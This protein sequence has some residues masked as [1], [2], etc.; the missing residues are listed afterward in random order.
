MRLLLVMPT[1]LRVGYDDYFS[2]APMG[3]ETLAAHARQFADV[4]LMDMRG[5][6]H[7]VEAHADSL[8]ADRPDIIGVSVNS[9]PHTKYA[10]ALAQALRRRDGRVR[11]LVGGQQA[12][13]LP[14]EMLAPGCFDALVRG[15]GEHAICEIL[16]RGGDAGGVPGVSWRGNGQIHHEPDRPL[17]ANLDEILPPAR[18][19]L[20]DRARYRMGKYRIE[21]IESSR[22]CPYM[23][24]FCSVRNFHRGKW[25]PKSVARVLQEVDTILELYHEPKVIYFADDNFAQDIG[26]VA[27]IC[28]G[29]IERRTDAH[30]W[31]QA[32]VDRL[33]ANPEVIALMGKAKFSAVLVGIETPVKR[34]LKEAKKGTSPE[35]IEQAIKLL[36]Q[37]DIGVWGTFTLGLPGETAEETKLT[38]GYLAKTKVDV[39]QITVATPIPGSQLYEDA[40]AKGEILSGDWDRFDFTSPLIKGQLDKPQLDALM[41]R[42][43]LKTYLSWRFFAALF[44][45]KTNLQRLRRTAFG[46]FSSF[47]RL[48]LKETLLSLF[49]RRK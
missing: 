48:A 28:T 23:C 31:C 39:A 38:A 16:R 10:L 45:Q 6:G 8:L 41:R 33:A 32:R 19:L 21:G 49:H 34:L 26:R 13:F 20:P 12:S 40:K 14:D 36:H 43:Y 22:G 27:E 29:I 47:L 24:S 4:A 11:L 37:H 46:V 3:I 18:D 30:F 25:R 5:N 35:Q 7:D 17:I 44:A 42:A 9:A 15:E 1:G 2:A